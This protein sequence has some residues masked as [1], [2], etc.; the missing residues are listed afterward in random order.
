MDDLVEG[1]V[2]PSFRTDRS[3]NKTSSRLE[4]QKL[5]SSLKKYKKLQAQ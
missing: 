1:P 2:A 4:E 3:P 5:E